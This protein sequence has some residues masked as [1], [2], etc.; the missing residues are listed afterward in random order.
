MSQVRRFVAA[1][2][3]AAAR[4]NRWRGGMVIGAIDETGQERPARPLPE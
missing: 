4:R 2:L 1:D 3:D